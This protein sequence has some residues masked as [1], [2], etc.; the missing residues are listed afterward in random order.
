M[1]YYIISEFLLHLFVQLRVVLVVIQ[2][3]NI[4]ELPLTD[5]TYFDQ[6]VRKS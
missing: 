1:E 4:L 6:G 2:L 3:L 5:Q